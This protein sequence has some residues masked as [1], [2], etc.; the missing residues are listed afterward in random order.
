MR[1][2]RPAEVDAAVR[3]LNADY[4]QRN[5]PYAIVATGDGYRMKLRDAFSRLRD[6]VYGKSRQARLSQAAIEVLAAVAYHEPISAEEVTRLR[7]TASGGVL[8]QL[9]R[10]Q[11]LRLERGGAPR[12]VAYFTTPRFLILFGLSSLADLPRS[13]ELERP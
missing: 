13:G 2:V 8:T 1:G 6:K 3:Q 7:G 12:R 5:C 11:L 4:Q 9:V 10:R